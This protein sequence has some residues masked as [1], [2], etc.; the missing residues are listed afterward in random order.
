MAKD[1][2]DNANANA[3]GMSN[4]DGLINEKD[5][6][7]I[8]SQQPDDDSAGNSNN[9]SQGSNS[10]KNEPSEEQKRLAA[11][12]LVNEKK[13]E[14]RL[15]LIRDLGLTDNASD[16]QIEEARNNQSGSAKSVL[17]NGNEHALDKDGNALTKDGTSVFKTKAELAAMTREKDSGSDDNE[18][19]TT[20]IEDYI[21]LSGIHPK[22]DEGK[23]RVY[24]DSVEGLMKL[25]KDVGDIQAKKAFDAQLNSNPEFK[26]YYEYLQRGGN[27]VDY[28]KQVASSWKHVKF[29]PK[30]TDMLTNVVVANLV[31]TGMSEEKA[32]VTAKLYADTNQLEEMGKDSYKVLTALEDKRE[33]DEKKFYEDESKRQE[34]ADDVHWK[35]VQKIVKEGKISNITIPESER[36]EFFK[37]VA[38]DADKKGNS[39]ASLDR[40]ALKTEQLLQL[41]YLLFKKFDLSKLVTSQVNT[42]KVKGLKA[43]FVDKQS[44]LEGGQGI[45]QDKFQKVANNLDDINIDSIQSGKK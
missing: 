28:H 31:R 19:E 15:A 20:A 21:K 5:L 45:N 18:E 34:E 37:Y 25:T 26:K 33:D 22:D 9:N 8:G 4:L 35:G 7:G 44:G 23:P 41:E 38:F 17:I 42:V 14:D 24:E 12:K 29:D 2:N 3:D 1:T 11:E 30:N 10:G 27:P 13:A 32:R 40:Q 39:Q 36:D 16:A 43:R 6:E